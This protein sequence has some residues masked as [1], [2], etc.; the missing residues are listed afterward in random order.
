[1]PRFLNSQQNYEKRSNF[2]TV[3][4]AYGNL[5]NMSLLEHIPA[6]IKMIM[7]FFLVLICIR[8]KLS[9][10]NAFLLGTLF[11]SFLFGLKPQVTLRSI[12]A[13]LT[14]PKTLSIAAVVSLILV[15]SRSM[16]RAGQ[17]QRMLKKFRGKVSSPRLNLVIFPAL[18]GLCVTLGIGMLLF[19]L[20]GFFS[21]GTTKE[22]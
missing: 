20:S 16:E 5:A 22:E 15:L 7:I 14:D 8:K 17:M 19:I 4:A 21:K 6:I 13:S 10:G 18:I 2:A 11:L 1:M 3:N 12:L 9:L